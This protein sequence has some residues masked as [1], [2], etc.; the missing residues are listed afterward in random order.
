MAVE[1]KL[2]HFKAADKGQ[3]ELY[4]R[5]LE[6]HEIEPGEETPIGLILC[7][8]KGD[9]QFEL[10]QLVPN[11]GPTLLASFGAQTGCVQC[12]QF[13]ELQFPSSIQRIIDCQFG[14]SNRFFGSDPAAPGGCFQERKLLITYSYNNH[15]AEVVKT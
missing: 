11:S 1:L 4:V 3:M 14:S 12:H 7:A 8:D 13:P 6:K 9:E 2:E 5:W 10:L 15:N